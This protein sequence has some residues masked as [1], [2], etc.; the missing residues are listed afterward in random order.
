MHKQVI[1]EKKKKN[2]CKCGSFAPA[3]PNH[4]QENANAI[5]ISHFPSAWK[6]RLQTQNNRSLFYDHVIGLFALG[7]LQIR[8]SNYAHAQILAQTNH[9]IQ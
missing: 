6:S 4:S 9:G 2:F 1:E 8:I 5:E 3:L 7:S